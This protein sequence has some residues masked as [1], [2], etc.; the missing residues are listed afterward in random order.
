[1]VKPLTIGLLLLGIAGCKDAVAPSTIVAGTYQLST[2]NGGPLPAVTA[3]QNPIS[4]VEER[5]MSGT[6]I[7]GAAG[8][9]SITHQL[10]YVVNGADV[11]TANN[12]SSV[13]TGTYT[14]SGASAT[15]TYSGGTITASQNG[16]KVTILS[17]DLTLVYAK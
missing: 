3:P 5:L 17:G 10:H 8:T 7:L 4:K 9:F 12:V 2:V 13:I 15:L 6:L 16:G 11:P 1:M 14:A